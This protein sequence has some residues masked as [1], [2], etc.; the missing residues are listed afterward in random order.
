MIVCTNETC[1]ESFQR[2]FLTTHLQLDCFYRMVG[3]QFCLVQHRLIEEEV[4][5]KLFII[6]L[7]SDLRDINKLCTIY[8]EF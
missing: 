5:M 6:N 4:R 3:C 7:F 8:F 1:K 2:I